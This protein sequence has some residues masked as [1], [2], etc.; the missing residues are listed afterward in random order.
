M[1]DSLAN[2]IQCKGN[3]VRF[4]LHSKVYYPNNNNA[5]S[6]ILSDGDLIPVDYNGVLPCIAVRKPTKYKVEYFEKLPW[7]QNSIGI[8]MA[9]EEVSP[10]FNL[11]WMI[12]NQF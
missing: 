5:Y 12:L 2:P 7:L 4:N 10:R 3:D 1:I 9:K 8:L 11:T 6:I